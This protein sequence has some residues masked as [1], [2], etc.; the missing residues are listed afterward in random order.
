MRHQKFADRNSAALRHPLRD[1]PLRNPGQSLDERIDSIVNNDIGSW[2][3]IALMVWF[4]AGWELF[5]EL[6]GVPRMPGK[7]AVAAI[8]LTA[9]AAWRIRHLRE[10]LR[11]LKLG[12]DGERFVG[13]FLEGLRRSGAHVFHDV[14]AEGF[15]IDHVIIG[16]Q[17]V[18]AIETKTWMKRKG[19]H[20]LTTHEGHIFRGGQKLKPN[21]IDQACGS[22]AWVSQR[23]SA[24]TG[25][26]VK[27]WPVLLFPGWFVEQDAATKKRAWVLNERGLQAFLE[28]ARRRLSDEEVA[29][30]ATHLAQLIRAASEQ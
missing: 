26:S 25:R 4:L 18:F 8:L 16:P 23:L 28:N 17:G 12:R 30:M 11:T 14:V 6:R 13:Q 10:K 7:F 24:S 3:L 5:A 1:R 15:N 20:V 27:A 2:I 29:M 9:L 21:P 22:A 19:T